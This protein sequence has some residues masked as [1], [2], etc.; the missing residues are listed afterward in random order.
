MTIK[1]ICFDVDDTLYPASDKFKAAKSPQH[2][3]RLI[4]L[5]KE[6][7]DIEKIGLV[8]DLLKKGGFN[9]KFDDMGI[10]GYTYIVN[11]YGKQGNANLYRLLGVDSSWVERDV[12]YIDR[13]NLVDW[14]YGQSIID[15]LKELKSKNISL[16][17]FS[18]SSYGSIELNLKYSGFTAE[19]QKKLFSLDEKTKLFADENI[20]ETKERLEKK[21]KEGVISGADFNYLIKQYEAKINFM[22]EGV[23]VLSAEDN[24][25]YKRPKLGG[26]SRIKQ[27][28]DISPEEILFAGD[29]LKKDVLPAKESG[30]KACYV[31][32]GNKKQEN[33]ADYVVDKLMEIGEIVK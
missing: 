2:V 8:E 33:N 12:Y 1:H 29:S 31:L 27:C 7:N 28:L 5:L 22:K 14:S 32:W 20:G 19:I 18:N 15:S 25:E 16:S 17:L 11:T 3:K 4:Q 10:E 13:K 23:N 30:L 26:F 21:L 6:K 9:S 24:S